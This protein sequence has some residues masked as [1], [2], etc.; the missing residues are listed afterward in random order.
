MCHTKKKSKNLSNEKV[1]ERER[2][3]E[4][5]GGRERERE[6]ESLIV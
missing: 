1:I 4:R 6:Y 3:R 5:G 2:E